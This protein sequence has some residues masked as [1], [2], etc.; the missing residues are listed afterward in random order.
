[1]QAHT[2]N[3]K[4]IWGM[5]RWRRKHLLHTAADVAKR[6]WVRVNEDHLTD[7]AAEVSFYFVLSLFPFF[8]VLAAIVGWLPSTDLW[9]S[10]AQW[11]IAYFPRLSR[12]LVFKTIL[13]L[14]HGY[15][16]FL[17]FG[18]ATT[19]WTASSGFMSL[20]DALTLV[21]GGRRDP[22]SYWKKRLMAIAATL[23]ANL[24]FILSFG[25]WTA[26]EWAIARAST[27]FRVLVAFEERWKVVWWL[28]TLVLLCIGLD[29]LN[30]FLPA[31]KRRWRWL[32]PG[33]VLVALSFG[34]ASLGLNLYVHYSPMLPRIYGTL[35]G[36]IVLML[37]IYISTVIV[38]IGAETDRVV[39]ELQRERQT[40]RAAA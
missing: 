23:G 39:D 26:G 4:T 25:L 28:L 24:F 29:L 21:Y 6:V 1:V 5:A 30:Y 33:T 11:V 38:L 14:A 22:R 18:L 34:L 9:Q 27:R 12:G 7:M 37:W 31:V 17:S 13:D 20:M 32:T 2:A 3:V 19:L 35:A 40:E 16:G 36:F 10:F 8:L 15:K